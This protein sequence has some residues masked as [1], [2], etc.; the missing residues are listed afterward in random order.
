MVHG[1]R[2]M[3]HL[4]LGKFPDYG[5][6]VGFYISMPR[7]LNFENSSTAATSERATTSMKVPST[8]TRRTLGFNFGNGPSTPCEVRRPSAIVIS[9]SKKALSAQQSIS[10][11]G[12]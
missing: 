3:V 6:H 5:S 7:Y 10:I 2:L 11:Y 1:P 9:T 4:V 8:K 12:P